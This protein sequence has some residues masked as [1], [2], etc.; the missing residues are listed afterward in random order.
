MIDGQI[1]PTGSFPAPTPTTESSKH[2]QPTTGCQ[3]TDNGGWLTDSGDHRRHSGHCHDLA[4]HDVGR[5]GTVP[6]DEVVVVT[7]D[8]EAVAVGVHDAMQ[9]QRPAKPGPVGHHITGCILRLS[10]D[11]DEVAGVE[12]GLH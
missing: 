1:M 8:H 5:F 9:D 11:H 6:V 4:A 12:V 3:Q 2:Q 7:L 10:P